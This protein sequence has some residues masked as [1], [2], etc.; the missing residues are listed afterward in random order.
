MH[1]ISS[2]CTLSLI[3]FFSSFVL[4]G[5][6]ESSLDSFKI[7]VEKITKIKILK[8]NKEK[9][10]YEIEIK[11]QLTNEEINV[12]KKELIKLKWEK[13]ASIIIKDEAV[14]GLE[15]GDIEFEV[16]KEPYR[17]KTSNHIVFLNLED[18]DLYKLVKKIVKMVKEDN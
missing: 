16:F 2:I 17:L 1:R 13:P 15:V 9:T 14:C 5:E 8:H 4:Y 18:G 12:F 10:K 3:F 7:D 6:G 11:Q